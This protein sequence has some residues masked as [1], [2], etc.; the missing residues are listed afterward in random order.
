MKILQAI[1]SSNEEA[2]DGIPGY[3]LLS[4]SDDMPDA[5]LKEALA[6]T[7]PADAGGEAI[8]S[9]KKVEAD[10]AGWFLLNRIVPGGEGNLSHTLAFQEEGLAESKIGSFLEEMRT[11]FARKAQEIS[12]DTK[13]EAEAILSEF[14]REVTALQNR[15]DEYSNAKWWHFEGEQ[16]I[17]RRRG[18][19]DKLERSAKN[20]AGDDLK[21]FRR[22]S[23]PILRLIPDSKLS[24]NSVEPKCFPELLAKFE[25]L[26]SDYRD[27]SR[28]I[29][30][31]DRANLAETSSSEA[32]AANTKYVEE[33]S[34]VK[35]ELE[36][37]KLSDKIMSSKMKQ[38]RKTS[39]RAMA[40]K[41]SMMSWQTVVI[42]VLSIAVAVLLAM[43]L[44]MKMKG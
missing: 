12:G 1:A 16:E 5:L 24:G 20:A 23:A 30:I 25:K 13:K 7:Y 17:Q 39:A 4:C 27:L 32:Q 43:V 28:I 35:R 8:Q 21:E 3:G 9:H 40:W 11:V 15:V 36:V 14:R 31:C 42:L 44:M 10:G 2:P 22:K 26:A 19:I 18:D 34:V 33:L 38:D 29:A 6:F 37:S 41:S